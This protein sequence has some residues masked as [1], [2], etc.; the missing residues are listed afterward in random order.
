MHGQTLGVR[1]RTPRISGD[2]PIASTAAIPG[3]YRAE[4][5][6]LRQMDGAAPYAKAGE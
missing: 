2:A 1:G 4:R 3:A 5:P 6:D